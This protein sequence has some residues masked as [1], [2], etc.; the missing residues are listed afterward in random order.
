[1]GE[2]D[3]LTVTEAA[4]ALGTSPQ[5]VRTLLRNGELRGRKRPWGTRYVW[6]PSQQG[7]DQFLAEFGR[8][9]G[10]RRA[11]RPAAP[12]A[13]ETAETAEGP[14]AA[15][16]PALAAVP[17]T[18]LDELFPEAPPGAPP[19]RP[20]DVSDLSEAVS[21]R[22]R[23]DQRP[24]VLRPRGRATV[25]V[26]VFGIPLFVAFAAA[27]VVPSALWFDELGQGD[28]FNRVV[29]AKV[30]LYLLIAGT[31]AIFVGANLA[32]ALRRTA[33]VET[34]VGVLGVMATAVVTATLFATATAGHWQTYELWR[35]RQ[36]FGVGDP[37]HGKDIGF[38]VFTLPFE[39][40]VSGWLLW[41]IPIGAGYAAIVY[42][43]RGAL[44]ARPPHADFDAQ[45]HLAVLAAL[46]LLVVAWRCRLEQF[47]L[48]LGQPS[49]DAGQSYAGAGYVDV[50]VRTPGLAALAALAVVLAVACLAAPFVA[51]NGH[52]RAATLVAGV[53]A[54]LLLVGGFL[55]SG[56]IPALVQRYS[57]DPNPLAS[58][59]PYLQRSIDAT[60]TGL[61]LDAIDVEPYS[62][63]GDFSKGGFSALSDRLKNVQVWD[64][65]V[66]QAR[67]RELVTDT[68]YFS[69]GQPTLDAVRLNGRR[70]PTVESARELDLRPVGGTADNWVN[71]RIA[72][73]HGLGLVRFSSTA[74]S[75]SREPRV[76]DTGL[77]L[78]QP[79]IYFG[80]LPQLRVGAEPDDGEPKIYTP[81]TDT[82]T[83]ESPWVLVD[84]RRPEVDIP[85]P[86][87]ATQADYHYTGS[88]G[89]EL[90]SWL[91]RAVFALAL[92]SKELL[93][94]DDITP[95]TRILLHRDVDERLQTLAPFIQWDSQAVPLTSD[96]RIVFVVDGY[97]T[98]Q[99]YPYAER[100][101][102]AGTPVTYARPSVRATV[103]AFSGRVNL[104]LVDD[105]D[106][107]AH[108]WAEIFPTLFRPGDTMPRELRERL[109]Y[110]YD[111]FAA[112]ATAYERFH[113]TEPDVFVSGSDA[114]TRPIALSGPLEVAGDV[115][116]DE[117]DEDELRLT[118]Q[119]GYAFAPPPGEKTPR[120]ILGTYYSPRQGQNLVASLTG[121]ID[122]QGRARLVARTL[123]RNPVTLGPAQVSRLVFATPRVRNLL[124]L[125]NLEVRDLDVSSLDTVLLGDPR[126]IF[127]SGGVIQIQSLYEG[128][129]GPGAARLLGVTAYLNGRAGLGPDIDSA[130]RQALNSPPE[131]DAVRPA[132]PVVVGTPVRLAFRVHNAE[133]EVV[134]V[135]S[136][137]N[138]QRTNLT[139][140]SGRGTV[141]WVPSDVG[142]ATVRVEVTGLDGTVVAD[143]AHFPVLSHAP[144]VKVSELPKRV[145]AGRP[146][147][148]LFT[149]THA[150][151]ASAEVS[152]RTGIVFT[153][154]YTLHHGT[155]VI[156]WTP[157]TAGEAVLL[158]RVGG[159]QGQTVRKRVPIEV[160]PGP[161][162]TPPPT[163]TI[164]AA[165]DLATVGK[166][167]D[168]AFDANGCEVAFAQI[169]GTS[170]EV[171]SWRFPCPA[172]KA[173]FRWTPA[174]PGDYVLKVVA[175]GSDSTT[176]VVTPLTVARAR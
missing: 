5:T 110:P 8:L 9:D 57:V 64:S 67:M 149:V 44:G 70:Q 139:L 120:L 6:V 138:R 98:S 137:G 79:R 50:H 49:G 92:G 154:L 131:V 124:G 157:K 4:E 102:L 39:S 135:I 41:L 140:R 88:G 22:E 1:M 171:R 59:L 60:R 132:D 151:N 164:V 130:I 24:F 25:V 38:F 165:P 23:Q 99:S 32:I 17:A 112:Q 62:P 27:R 156:A 21:E 47:F 66:L 85:R 74:T 73:T 40:L 54:L 114:W 80:N 36:S 163:V 176:Q 77:G 45:L 173:A 13:Q 174:K 150:V 95:D 100:V 42:R 141:E 55:A 82:R 71:D 28:V 113:A 153:R 122:P 105:S 90:S 26:V 166:P 43:A 172:D 101:S 175:R 30:E 84:T 51:R 144:T 10:R 123:A 61:G 16:A 147:R 93:L 56:L 76:L 81:T 91:R 52:V 104:Y 109:R 12:P 37:V 3:D 167:A 169:E 116:F 155:G 148:L 103:D 152:T 158:I 18:A 46:F 107:I 142:S 170:G 58:E 11:P 20:A 83:A 118:M 126:L 168:F 19:T 97:T 127:L 86:D 34:G 53:P 72:Y 160:A 78:R 128:S 117:S 94:S 63:T 133:R 145:V 15:P 119:P 143:T 161:K 121:W 96:G 136:A 134:T 111:L 159:H 2:G 129:R 108:A 106:P 162:T 65:W 115:N 7:V 29:A 31:V 75:A 87:G 33:I 68:P 14:E 89:I 48:E 146:L 35:H 69:P 125:R